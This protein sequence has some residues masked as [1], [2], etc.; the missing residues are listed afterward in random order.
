MIDRLAPLDDSCYICRYEHNILRANCLQS[1]C[2]NKSKTM[3][4]L[5]KLP[6]KK[7][8]K[9]WRKRRRENRQ[10][11]CHEDGEIMLLFVSYKRLLKTPVSHFKN[12]YRVHSSA[13]P[14]ST[15][16]IR[17]YGTLV[18]VWVTALQFGS[19]GCA[20]S[21]DRGGRI[22]HHKEVEKCE[23]SSLVPWQPFQCWHFILPLL[24]GFCIL[25]KKKW[26]CIFVVSTQVCNCLCV[27]CGAQEP[28]S[29]T[30]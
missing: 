23:S 3:S 5:K 12:T 29:L 8:E 13:P 22:W 1:N 19:P 15:Y 17:W 25:K 26:M 11:Y 16:S 30:C 27:L 24:A 28:C 21:F 4:A 9:Q 7:E 14:S 2:I 20:A 6:L 10:T 18:A